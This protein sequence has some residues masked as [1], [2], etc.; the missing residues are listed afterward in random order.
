ML[1]SIVFLKENN[2][3]S[4][5]TDVDSI[6]NVDKLRKESIVFPNRFIGCKHWK[7]WLINVQ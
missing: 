5:R 3:T 6:E 2:L 4:V 7:G 1:I